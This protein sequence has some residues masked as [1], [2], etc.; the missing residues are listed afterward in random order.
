M[1]ILSSVPETP[2]TRR[3]PTP[4]QVAE[5]LRPTDGPADPHPEVH[6]QAA[7]ANRAELACTAAMT[8]VGLA[9]CLGGQPGILSGVMVG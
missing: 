3:G 1:R 7:R 6:R 4:T 2:A 8:G 5:L 9:S